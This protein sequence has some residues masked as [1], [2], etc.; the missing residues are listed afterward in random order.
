M[1][2]MRVA[3][4]AGTS[5]QWGGRHRKGPGQESGR[6]PGGPTEPQEAPALPPLVPREVWSALCSVP[7]EIPRHR[8]DR[9]AEVAGMVAPSEDSGSEGPS[10]RAA[11]ARGWRE[12]ACG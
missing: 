2:V 12:E 7:Q 10:G 3:V 6:A 5:R 9:A 8:Q 1:S 4:T 11:Q